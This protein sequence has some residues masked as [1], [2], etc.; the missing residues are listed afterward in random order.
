MRAAFPRCDVTSL[1]V[2][3]MTISSTLSRGWPIGISIMSCDMLAILFGQ[4]LHANNRIADGHGKSLH[5]ISEFPDAAR[6]RK[7][8]QELNHVP[9][10]A[11]PR[12]LV[13]CGKLPKKP[14]RKQGYIFPDRKSTRLNS[15]H[16]NISYA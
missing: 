3:R 8:H 10:E 2:L 16:A 4:I 5:Q 14:L 15:S 6:P 9:S 12:L 7:P 1:S 11:F 13:P